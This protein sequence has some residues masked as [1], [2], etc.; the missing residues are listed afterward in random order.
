[1]AH[2]IIDKSDLKGAVNPSM[3]ALRI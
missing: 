3:G 1:M 2:L